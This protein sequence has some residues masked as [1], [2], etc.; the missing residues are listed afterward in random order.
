MTEGFI[1]IEGTRR[2]TGTA[3]YDTPQQ[4][5]KSQMNTVSKLID[6]CSNCKINYGTII[7]EMLPF[8]R[9]TVADNHPLS[10]DPTTLGLHL[11]QHFT[12]CKP[13]AGFQETDIFQI[14]WA[15]HTGTKAFHGGYFRNN[16][17]WIQ[18]G[19]KDS[20]SDV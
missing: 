11:V 7:E 4:I 19:Q 8:T 2:E 10:S 13:V 6:L 15:C 9:P 18:A 5:L 3:S 17:V 14:H 20:Y 12:H 16:Q 1:I